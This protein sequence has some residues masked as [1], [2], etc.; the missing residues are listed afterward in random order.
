VN[1]EFRYAVATNLEAIVDT[2]NSTI[3]GRLVTA[4]LEPVSVESK[5]AWFEAHHS[6]TRPLWVL[7]LDGNY[8]GWM[9]FNSFYGR[10]AY[11]GTAELSIYLEEKFRGKGIGH[12]CMKYA[13][14][15][16]SSCGIHTLLGFIFGHNAVSIHLFEQHGFE[17]WA[18][19]PEV[20]NMD[21]VYRD[22]LIFGRNLKTAAKP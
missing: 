19:L 16:A 2:Y 17:K 12:A 7:N 20:A 13:V 14:E 4:D 18:H 5:R 3:S 9:S 6:Q 11:S 22:L 10:P 1:L 8:A 21:G 15:S